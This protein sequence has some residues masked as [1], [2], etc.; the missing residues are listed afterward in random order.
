MHTPDH[1]D[2]RRAF[3][4]NRVLIIVCIVAILAG[5]SRNQWQTTLRNATWLC[6]SCIGLE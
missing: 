6:T 3:V 5:L 2:N 4:I 1:D